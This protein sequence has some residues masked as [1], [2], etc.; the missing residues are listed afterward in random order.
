MSYNSL[1]KFDPT[2]ES[3]EDFQEIW[4][5]LRCQLLVYELSKW[6]VIYS[7]A[8]F[9]HSKGLGAIHW[10]LRFTEQDKLKHLEL[11]RLVFTP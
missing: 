1:K 5:L 4:F 7:L 8:F 6:I 10:Q 3:I 2:K 11:S 9:W